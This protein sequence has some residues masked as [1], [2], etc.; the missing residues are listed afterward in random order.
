S[1]GSA[2]AYYGSSVSTNGTEIAIAA[3]SARHTDGT[4]TVYLYQK[5]GTDWST[6]APDEYKFTNQ[7]E[8]N[9]FGTSLLLRD[10]QLV[11]GESGA[12]YVYNKS[13]AT[14]DPGTVDESVLTKSTSEYSNFGKSVASSGTT[15]AAGAPTLSL[16][17][18]NSGEVFVFQEDSPGTWNIT[19]ELNQI[20]TDTAHNVGDEFGKIISMDDQ[21]MLIVA[22][23][24]DSTLAPAGVLYVYAKNDQGTTSVV[25]DTWD[26]ET[27]FTAPDAVNTVSFADSVAIDGS[28]FLVSATLT[29][30]IAEVYIYERNGSDWTTV[31]PTVT[32]LLTHVS[33][34]LNGQTAVAIEE[35]TIVIGN[36]DATGNATQSGAVYV[37]EQ[38]G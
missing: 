21:Y 14:W 5:N 1:D 18:N 7:E 28:T 22:P 20:D 10:D 3:R 36:Q 15:V 23:G 19:D 37:Y 8:G 29:G 4:G 32:P 6:I 34:T 26:Y 13:G 9:F 35:Q 25:D 33:R 12:A 38:N 24:T 2:Y 30:G 11:V 31:A 16:D 17:G 27:S